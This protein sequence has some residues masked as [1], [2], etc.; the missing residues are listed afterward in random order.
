MNKSH[1]WSSRFANFES[2]HLMQVLN[3]NHCFLEV[4]ILGNRLHFFRGKLL[5]RTCG[6]RHKWDRLNHF[7]NLLFRLFFCLF[8]CVFV[9][10]N[11]SVCEWVW[12]CACVRLPR[13]KRLLLA[14]W[15]FPCSENTFLFGFTTLNGKNHDCV[16]FLWKSSR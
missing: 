6:R 2:V 11:V 9:C 16:N 12:V 1:I 7:T 4:V 15:F 10:L 3:Q 8:E 5:D 14:I 13:A